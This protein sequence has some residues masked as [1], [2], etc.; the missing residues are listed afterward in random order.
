MDD[1]EELEEELVALWMLHRMTQSG[2]DGGEVK[3]KN[4]SEDS[5]MGWLLVFAFLAATA[6]LLWRLN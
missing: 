5:G 1:E 2:D 6:Y 3:S 4:E